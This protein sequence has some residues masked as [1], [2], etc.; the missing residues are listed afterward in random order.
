MTFQIDDKLKF[1][2]SVS[3]HVIVIFNNIFRMQKRVIRIITNIRRRDSC[4]EQF[5]KLQILPFQSQYIL[6]LLLCVIN[7]SDMYEHNCEIHTVN[8]R[9]RTNL[10]LPHLRQQ[11][12]KVPFILASRFTVI[13]PPI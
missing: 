12:K 6:S 7:S 10:H 11:F 3:A 2:Q 8:T 9:D 4:R 13:I 1:L 5:R